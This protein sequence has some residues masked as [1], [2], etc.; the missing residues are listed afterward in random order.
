MPINICSSNTLS[1]LLSGDRYIDNIC[2]I[3][4]HW[5]IIKRLKNTF[6]RKCIR[7]RIVAVI[8]FKAS[9]Q[10]CLTI[11]HS[12]KNTYMHCGHGDKDKCCLISEYAIIILVPLSKK[13][14]LKFLTQT[15]I[16]Q[17]TGGRCTWSCGHGGIVRC[18]FCSRFPRT[19]PSELGGNDVLVMDG[20]NDGFR[21]K[22]VI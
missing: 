8:Y 4:I 5:N 16:A 13:S 15:P 20:S 19:K 3:M 7:G 18:Q 12:F 17:S 14:V 9:R 6:Q 1:L 2:V 11:G 22:N 10:T 21:G